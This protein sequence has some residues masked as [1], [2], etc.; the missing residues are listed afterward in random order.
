V[1]KPPGVVRVAVVGDSF[2]EAMH[3]PYEQTFCAVM[4]RDLARCLPGGLRP[5]CLTLESADTEPR[6]NS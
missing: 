1:A 3:V 5:R 4:E 2:T 6:K